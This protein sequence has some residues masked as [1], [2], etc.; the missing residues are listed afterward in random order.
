MAE[1]DVTI[2]NCTRCGAELSVPI[3]LRQS[4]LVKLN[5][6]NGAFPNATINVGD[7]IG[8][9]F[10]KNGGN[11]TVVPKTYTVQHT[12]ASGHRLVAYVM[13]K[14]EEELIPQE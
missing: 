10:N 3:K 11:M 9:A 4:V 12:P 7:V 5:G 8:A 1:G 2:N 13:L 14:I 6:T